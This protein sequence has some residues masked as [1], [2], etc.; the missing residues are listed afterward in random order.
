MSKHAMHPEY[1]LPISQA[2]YVAEMIGMEVKNKKDMYLEFVEVFPGISMQQFQ[3][4]LNYV[5]K[6]LGLKKLAFSQYDDLDTLRRNL[7]IEK[8][9]VSRMRGLGKHGVIE[10][11]KLHEEGRDQ[12]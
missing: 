7:S 12:E 8:I 10:L 5:K 1:N 2:A 9:R 11:K 4:V 3:I 6:Q